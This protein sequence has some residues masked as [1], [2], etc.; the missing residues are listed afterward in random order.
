[1]LARGEE[2]LLS[3]YMDRFTCK[4]DQ[5][6]YAWSIQTMELGVCCPDHVQHYPLD[7]DTIARQMDAGDDALCVESPCGEGFKVVIKGSESVCEKLMPR[8]VMPGNARSCPRRKVWST[9]RQRC[10]RVFAG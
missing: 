4:L 2:Q 6:S 8:S 9:Y 5:F 1:M 7:P 3:D 10:V